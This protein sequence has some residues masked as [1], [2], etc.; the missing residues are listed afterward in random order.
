MR[1]GFHPHYETYRQLQREAWNAEIA[2][3]LES[4]N[5]DGSRRVGRKVLEDGTI[6][7]YGIPES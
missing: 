6:V 5:G 1:Y 3:I 7:D 2:R 4:T